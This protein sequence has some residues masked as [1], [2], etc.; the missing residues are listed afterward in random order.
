MQVL[1]IIPARGGPKGIPKKNLA[2]HLGRPLLTWPVDEA[3]AAH[4][5]VRVVRSTDESE[6]PSLPGLRCR[7]QGRG[8]PA[9]TPITMEAV[10]YHYWARRIFSLLGHPQRPVICEIGGGLGGQA[11]KVLGKHLT[12]EFGT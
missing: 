12:P 11:F 4:N 3:V 1:G 8:N 9:D 10:R 6:S 2:P 7:S 5:L